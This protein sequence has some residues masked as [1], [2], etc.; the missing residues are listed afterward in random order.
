M[1]GLRSAATA[2]VLAAAIPWI[3]GAYAVFFV[4]AQYTGSGL[5][6]SYMAFQG[7][8]NLGNV[9]WF[10]V[11]SGT[12]G[13]VCWTLVLRIARSFDARKVA[14]FVL[15]AYA[16]PSMMLIFPDTAMGFAVSHVRAFADGAAPHSPLALFLF[17]SGTLGLIVAVVLSVIHR[18]SS[19]RK[20]VPAD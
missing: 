14:P 12:T 17:Q 8:S 1:R 6:E 4:S 10:V 11:W 19:R 3:L 16:V 2:L 13:M 18:V 20:R 15:F 9:I 5:F 7:G